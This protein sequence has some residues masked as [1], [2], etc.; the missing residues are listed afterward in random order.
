MLGLDVGIGKDNW[1]EYKKCEIIGVDKSPNSKANIILN[2]EGNLPFRDNAFDIVLGI[3]SFNYV[4]NSRQLLSEINRVLKEEGILVCSVD[5]EKSTSHPHI[6]NEKYLKRVLIVTGFQSIM[7]L[8]EKFYA[9]W[10]NRT[11]VYAFSVVKKSKSKKE[12]SPKYCVKCGRQLNLEWE[13]D[14]N[15]NLFHTKCPPEKPK[16]YAKSYSVE[17]THPDQ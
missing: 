13:E 7:T 4:E 1:K 5:N 17:T 9:K 11:S 16:T 15:G 10:Y 3:N 8:V 14:G 2:L 6:W 12:S